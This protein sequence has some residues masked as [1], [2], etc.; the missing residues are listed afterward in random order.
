[1]T[2]Y[3]CER[4]GHP[5]PAPDH[6]PR[7]TT[8][9]VAHHLGVTADTIR[10]YRSRGI[11]PEPDGAF[12]REEWWWPDTITGWQATRPGRGVGGG[13]PRKHT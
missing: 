6:D 12:G 11:L 8:L 9:D 4:C 10:A 7:M 1:M 13:R 5:M 2:G 3:V